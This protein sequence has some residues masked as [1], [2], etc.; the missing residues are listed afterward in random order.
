MAI[1]RKTI[2][3]SYYG[4]TAELTP[5]GIVTPNYKGY[6]YAYSDWPQSLKD[7]YAYNPT[8]AKRLLADAG[9]PNGFKT[10]V[11]AS[12][13]NDSQ[14]LQA[15]QS[16]FKDIGVDMTI[17]VFD[18]T[19]TES[20]LRAGKQDQLST[21]EHA[22]IFPP[23]RIIDRYFSKGGDAILSGVNDANYD[24]FRAGFIGATNVEDSI[25]AFQ[26]AD[27][28][29]IENHWIIL[30]NATNTYNFWQPRIKGYSSEYLQWGM[31]VIFAR[32]WVSEP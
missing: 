14:L 3:Q 6:A 8:A 17:N 13:A 27:K 19:T 30:G 18:P 4:G 32:L 7:E 11:I 9:F 26:N 2:A 22:K 10:N 25:K 31:G 23:T 16:M 28:Y 1:D 29:V 21:G 12:T 15:W 20:M 24:A 5:A